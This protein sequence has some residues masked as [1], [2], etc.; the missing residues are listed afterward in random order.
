MSERQTEEEVLALAEKI[1]VR[2]AQEKEL[3]DY[4][5][6]LR[7]LKS[8]LDTCTHRLSPVI[9]LYLN[10]SCGHQFTRR[11]KV[12]ISRLISLINNELEALDIS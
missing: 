9:E 11:I 7:R 1:R 2:R 12:P 4:D 8:E 6:N 5:R 3:S 10:Q